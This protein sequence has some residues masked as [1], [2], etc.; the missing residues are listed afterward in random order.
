[1]SVIEDV[2][3]FPPECDIALFTFNW[4]ALRNRHIVVIYTGLP[5]I[6]FPALPGSFIPGRTKAD[7]LNHCEKVWMFP[8]KALP[9]TSTPLTRRQVY[10]SFADDARV[11]RN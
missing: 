11:V 1:M 7:V 5:D 3:R 2:V 10:R 9:T 4:K 8:E 6:V